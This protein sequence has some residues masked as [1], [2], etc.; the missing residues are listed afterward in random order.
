[1]K[2]KV[3]SALKKENNLNI[4]FS[5]IILLKEKLKFIKSL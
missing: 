2:F 1:M 3:F 4:T 5:R